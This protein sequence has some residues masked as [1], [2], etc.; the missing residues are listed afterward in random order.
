MIPQ[1]HEDLVEKFTKKRKVPP[2]KRNMDVDKKEEPKRID[3][4]LLLNKWME[5]QKD[6]CEML[7]TLVN[8]INELEQK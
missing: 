4:T 8:K 3:V 2:R 7:L 1:P 5:A 6:V